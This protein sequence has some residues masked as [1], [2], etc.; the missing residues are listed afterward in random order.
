MIHKDLASLLAEVHINPISYQERTRAQNTVQ[1]AH[2]SWWRFYLLV[3]QEKLAGATIAAYIASVIV[4]MCGGLFFF[5]EFRQIGQLA[6]GGALAVFAAAV[7]ITIVMNFIT[8][9]TPISLYGGIDALQYKAYLHETSRRYIS[10]L[11]AHTK[12]AMTFSFSVKR[13][14]DTK[15]A[16]TTDFCTL[17]VQLG[18]QE[19]LIDIWTEKNS[20]WL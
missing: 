13:F 18:H 17:Y 19:A 6:V 10:V 2:E 3:H 1:R 20:D 12:V 5:F 4:C 15:S 7:I 8:F 9:N 16:A 14:Y 11:Q